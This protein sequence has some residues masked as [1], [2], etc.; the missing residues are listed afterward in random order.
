M[1]TVMGTPIYVVSCKMWIF[2]FFQHDSI[3]RVPTTVFMGIIHR[4]KMCRFAEDTSPNLT[5]KA[6]GFRHLKAF[7]KYDLKLIVCGSH[8]TSFLLFLIDF[9]CLDSL[10]L[11]QSVC[12][13]SYTMFSNQNPMK[14]PLQ[15]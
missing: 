5:Q 15:C 6:K 2:E 13:V 1:N 14:Y 11:K 4:S 3:T 12:S 7:H 9:S 10:S 8:C